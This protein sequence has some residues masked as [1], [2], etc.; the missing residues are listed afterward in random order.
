[1]HHANKMLQAL[2]HVLADVE[3]I[4]KEWS[5]SP[6]L[7]RHNPKPVDVDEFTA[8]HKSLGGN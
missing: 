2:K 3:D 4:L 6:L 8:L 5:Q 1:M 7:I